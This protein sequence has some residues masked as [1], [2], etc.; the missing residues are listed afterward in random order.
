MPDGLDFEQPLLDSRSASRRSRR[1]TIRRTRTRSRACKNGSSASASA[2]TRPSP[3]GS[4]RSWRGIQASPHARL[5]QA[6]PRGLHRAATGDRSSANDPASSA[7]SRFEASRC[8]DRHQRPRHREKIRAQLRPCRTPRATAS[9]AL[10]ELAASRQADRH[11]HRHARRVSGLGAES[12]ASGGD[13]AQLRRMA[14]LP[15]P[16]IAVVTGEGGSGGALAIGM[17]NRVLMLEHPSTRDLARG[18][19]RFLATRG[20]RRRRRRRCAR[21]APEL[22][23]LGVI[24]G[25]VPSRSAAPTVTGGR[26][27][28]PAR[29]AGRSAGRAEAKIARGVDHG[30][31]RE[32]PADGRLRGGLRAQRRGDNESR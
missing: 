10:M 31:L 13:R 3:R 27:P 22:L 5:V 12:A 30:A 16:M 25:I 17:G 9:A 14:S 4:A 28:E 6:A 21:R 1:P 20:K 8:R 19:A 15:T 7:G 11:V 23:R 2:R 18:C 26:P 24:D 29:G 32:V